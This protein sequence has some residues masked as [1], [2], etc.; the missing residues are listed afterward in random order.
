MLICVSVSAFFSSMIS[1]QVACCTCTFLQLFFSSL[2]LYLFLFLLPLL[3]LSLQPAPN[4]ELSHQYHTCIIM[5]SSIIL[6]LDYC[7]SSLC[8]KPQK[9]QSF[10]GTLT[11]IISVVYFHIILVVMLHMQPIWTLVPQVEQFAYHIHICAQATETRP[12]NCFRT[13]QLQKYSGTVQ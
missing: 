13:K 7:N 8:L 11:S 1:I 10:F 5:C 12:N 6:L 9:K 2:L 3:F 4:I